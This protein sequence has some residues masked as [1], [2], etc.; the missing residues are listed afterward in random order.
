[1]AIR[2]QF[3]DAMSMLVSSVSIVTTDGSA[4]RAGAT[5]SAMTS[6][7]ADGEAPTVLVCLHH[8]SSAAKPLLEN[9]CFSINVLDEHQ[10]DIANIFAS[11]H[12]APNGDK[13][14][15]TVFHKGPSGAPRMVDALV[16]FDCEV[17]SH[18][19]IGTH[20]VIIGRVAQV[21]TKTGTPLLY[22]NRSY[23]RVAED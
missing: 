20:Y 7:S 9:G 12:P 11:R 1:M 2:T 17:K 23:R 8:D 18:E 4:G 14:D 19:Q 22:G 3:L 16:S 15:A 10:Q 5:V 6:V 13:F 21:D